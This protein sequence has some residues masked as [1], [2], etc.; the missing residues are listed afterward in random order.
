MMVT[1]MAI[2]FADKA[3]IGLAAPF[4]SKDMHLTNEQFGEIGSAFFLLFSVSAA[5]VGFVVDRISGKSVLAVM[6][7]IWAATQMPMIGE[8]SFGVLVVSR[9][10][11]GA[12]EGPAFP[13]ALHAV[14]KWFP[15]AKRAIPTSLVSIGSSVGVGLLSPLLMWIIVSYGWHTAFGFLG[16]AGFIWLAIW[17]MVGEEGPL[18]AAHVDRPA[19]AR[20]VP[21]RMLLTS[22]TFIG[23][24]LAGFAS[25]WALAVG[26]VWA[27]S[28]F[29]KAIGYSAMS[30]GW[31]VALPPMAQIIVSPISGLLTQALDRRGVSSRV[32]RGA[33]TAGSVVI[34]GVAMILLAK[35]SGLIVPV[36]L[37]VIALSFCGITYAIGPTLIGEIT[38]AGQ[39]GAILGISNALFSTAGLVAPWVIGRV[40]D[41][42]ASVSQG[43]RHAFM[44]SGML[45]VICA[46]LATVLIHPK[47]DIARFDALP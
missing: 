44:Y 21:Y 23:V 47:R 42:G 34:A 41:A 25:Y 22:R 19:A 38:P 4:I 46:L 3:V 37:S 10:V 6:A 28:F 33:F 18:D 8:V 35:S 2:N 9:V 31:I 27:P 14:Y 39:R 20:Q 12:A 32:S 16:V 5:I 43:F 11:L 45:I 36:P 24:T 7:F 26:I 1:F 13:V 30:T 17:M 40:V 15:N 29:V